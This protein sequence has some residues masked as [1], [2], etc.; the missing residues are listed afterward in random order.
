M[1]ATGCEGGCVGVVFVGCGWVSDFW[2]NGIAYMI[3]FTKA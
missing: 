2:T 3:I 1:N